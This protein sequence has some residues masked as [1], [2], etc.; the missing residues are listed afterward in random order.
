[1]PNDV[2]TAPR[3]ALIHWILLLAA[4]LLLMLF[5][6]T[7]GVQ[8]VSAEVALTA[9]P[10][11]TATVSMVE[12]TAQ[13]TPVSAEGQ[14][15]LPVIANPI[16]ILEPTPTPSPTPLPPPLAPPTPV[17]AAPPIDFD[18]ARQSAQSQGMEIATNKIGFHVGSGGTQEGLKDYLTALDAAG[19]PIFLKS[20]NY[21]EPLYIVQQLMKESGV[22][23]ILVYRD[24]D[25]DLKEYEYSLDPE[26]AAEM[27]W[28][29]NVAAVPPELDAKSIWLETVN[30]PDKNRSRWLAEFSLAS[31]E[32]AVAEG[33]KYAAFSWSSGEPEPTDWESPEMLAFLRFA[34]EHPDQ[35]AIALHEYSYVK[36]D[37]GYI[38]PWL[39]GRF[40]KIFRVADAHG[41][42]RPT[43]LI[44]EWGWEY[45]KLPQAEDEV[46]VA[47]AMA[48]IEWASWLYA[49][50]PEV[51]GAAIWYLG[52][53]FSNIDEQTQQ[54]I[55]PLQE[56]SLSNYFVY[57][58]GF[59]RID[60]TIFEPPEP[61]VSA[62]WL[63]Q[64]YRFNRTSRYATP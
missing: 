38:Y 45:T 25:E 5:M 28:R 52:P 61:S 43:I 27:L 39:I 46:D 48:D 42:P 47:Q 24:V 37:I 14:L 23:H 17:A 21:A 51:K 57:D 12:P 10:S 33:Y 1:M 15:F 64:S 18:A 53:G 11:P 31:A 9:T 7:G 2:P 19:V 50:Y 30:E 55:A 40:Q 41:I 63:Y 56:Y 32:I 22:D 58:P 8:S 6:R 16:I 13:P 44:T 3:S 4:A 20:A 34:G 26:V 49:A 35:V 29:R 54:L 62:E 36:E 59:G 60:E